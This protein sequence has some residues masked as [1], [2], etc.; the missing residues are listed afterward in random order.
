MGECDKQ[1]QMAVLGCVVGPDCTHFDQMNYL[2]SSRW[3]TAPDPNCLGH[4]ALLHSSV[5]F[6]TLLFITCACAAL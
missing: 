3:T 5:T 6:L 2:T 4:L 1:E